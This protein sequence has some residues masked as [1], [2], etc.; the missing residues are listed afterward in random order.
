MYAE[1]FDLKGVKTAEEA[2]EISKLNWVAEPQELVTAGG[3]SV[4]D[5]KAIVRSDNNAVIGVV[6]SRYTVQQNSTSFSFFDAICE[7]YDARYDA[8]FVINGGS[9]I[10][11]EASV[12]GGIPIRKG[13]EV[14]KKIRLMNTFDG[15]SLFT[16]SY[17]FFRLVCSNGL[18]AITKE[19][20]AFARHTA[21][22]EERSGDILFALAEDYFTKF[23]T[24]CK[25]L[26]N[27][28]L[29]AQMVEKFLKEMIG[30]GKSTRNKNIR[31]QVTELYEAGKGTGKGTSWDIYN[32]YVEWVDHFRGNDDSTRLANSVLGAN[33]LKEHALETALAL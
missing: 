15:T 9:K 28:I 33:Y 14:M 8:A 13:D 12:N 4:P 7:K 19:N 3:I 16:M 22:I 5:H 31:D 32:G 2:L 17:Y 27:K 20:K 18:M 30:E 11:L 26:A 29:D 24:Q 6:G 23:E 10:I 25:S 1:K 21:H